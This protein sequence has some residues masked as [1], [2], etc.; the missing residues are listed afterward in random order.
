MKV[1]RNRVDKRWRTSPGSGRWGL[2]NG[3][4]TIRI[5]ANGQKNGASTGTA[6]VHDYFVSYV[7]AP[8]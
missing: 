5:V 7:D 1:R 3:A 4:H 8:P 2:A 6:L